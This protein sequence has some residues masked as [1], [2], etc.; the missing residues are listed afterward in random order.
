MPLHSGAQCGHYPMHRVTLRYDRK[1][2]RQAVASFCWRVVGRRY[3]IALILVAAPLV[4]LVRGG[5][6]SWLVGV[7]AS[8]LALG[9]AFPVALYATHYR[10]A[11]RRLDAMGAPV[12][13]LEASASSL[14]L[15]SAAGTTTLPWSAVCDVWRFESCWLLLLSKSQF[16]TLPLAD[17]SAEAAEFIR[18]QVLAAGGKVF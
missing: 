10:N 8:V 7:Q 2:I 18:T 5:N 15:S 3:V 16:V 12:G 17:L 14:S 11:L 9:I 6:A 4:V 13:T 1:L